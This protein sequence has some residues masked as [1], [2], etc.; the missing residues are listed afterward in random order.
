MERAWSGGGGSLIGFSEKQVR[1]DNI[2]THKHTHTYVVC[3]YKHK[4]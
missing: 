3:M 1:F 4:K 2:R